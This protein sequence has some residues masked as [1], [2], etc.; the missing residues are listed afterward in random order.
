MIKELKNKIEKLQQVNIY[1]TKSKEE[2][3][4]VIRRLENAN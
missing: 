4:D 1:L 3:E 2:L